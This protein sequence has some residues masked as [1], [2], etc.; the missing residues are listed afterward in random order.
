MIRSCAS[1]AAARG[2]ALPENANATCLQD[3]PAENTTLANLIRKDGSIMQGD[4]LFDNFDVTVDGVGHY[5]ADPRTIGVRCVTDGD[6]LGLQFSGMIFANSHPG[7]DASVVMQISYDMTLMTSG[8][9]IADSTLTFEG[10]SKSG[11]GFTQ[12]VGNLMDGETLVGQASIQNLLPV[13]SSYT[14]LDPNMYT[15]LHVVN[16]IT[17]VAGDNDLTSISMVKQTFTI[18]PE[19]ASVLFVASWFLFMRR[20]RR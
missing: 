17:V 18:V 6:E 4:T 5:H 7:S 19:P 9:T 8:L 14:G 16:E 11:D 2:I 1:R 20:R 13:L 12:V 15:Q 3:P 10:E